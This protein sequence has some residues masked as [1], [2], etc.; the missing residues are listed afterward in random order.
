[1]RA[2]DSTTCALVTMRVGEMA[3]PLPWP[4]P[5]T[6]PSIIA[7]VTTRTTLRDAALISSAAR[8]GRVRAKRARSTVSRRVMARRLAGREAKASTGAV[9][10]AGGEAQV[11]GL[12][13]GE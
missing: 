7:T 6:S 10:P 1:M 4:K 13:G 11:A 9:G 5:T 3:M 12:G 8:A 2:A